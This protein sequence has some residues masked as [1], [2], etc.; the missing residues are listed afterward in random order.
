MTSERGI[1]ELKEAIGIIFKQVND[2]GI[3]Q[4]NEREQDKKVLNEW[5]Q[6]NLNLTQLLS[7]QT[8][9]IE[10][11]TQEIKNKE[12]S[13]RQSE[14]NSEILLKELALL[15]KQFESIPKSAENLELKAMRKQIS[16]VQTVVERQSGEIKKAVQ[17]AETVENVVHKERVRSVSMTMQFMK[18]AHLDE[19]VQQ[20]VNRLLKE[21]IWYIAF[22]GLLYLIFA[23]LP[24]IGV[25]IN[26]KNLAPAHNQTSSSATS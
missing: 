4:K 20:G 14:P 3:S 15:K 9:T 10:F 2:L 6:T 22:G 25:S 5:A 13:W 19:S 11:L 24:W 8:A 16:E 21:K 18:A 23:A 26:N 12:N 1:G 17:S 7:R